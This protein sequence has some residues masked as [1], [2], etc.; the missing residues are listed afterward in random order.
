MMNHLT[1]EQLVLYYYCEPNEVAQTADHLAGCE[2]CRGNYQALQRVL[3]SVDSL[4]VP[5]QQQNYEAA[6]WQ[7][8]SPK[9]APK[10]PWYLWWPLWKPLGLAATAVALLVVTFLAGQQWHN[11]E[12]KETLSAADAEQ[13]RERVLLVAVGGHLERS[14]TILVELANARTTAGRLDITFEQNAAEDLLDAN[15]LY[16]QTASSTGDV[17]TATLLED[18]ERVLV[19]IAHSP[20]AVSAKQLEELRKQIEDR[21]LLFKVKVFGSQ[22][23][24]RG[25]APACSKSEAL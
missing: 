23:E 6:L 12:S 24:N 17:S 19:E 18:L 3:N 1:E 13:V 16:R 10:K 4:P 11:P 14:Q 21:G 20:S 8:L 9:L 15:R 22:M 2:A 25:A 7:T 5:E